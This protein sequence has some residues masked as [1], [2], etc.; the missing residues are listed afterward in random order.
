MQVI[1]VQLTHDELELLEKRWPKSKGNGSIEGRA[2]EIVQL[3]FGRKD[4]QC[5]FELPER[6]ADLHVVLSGQGEP[7]TIEV[8]GTVSRGLAWNQI[9]VSSANSWRLLTEKSM[10]VYRVSDVFGTSPTIFVLLHG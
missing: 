6:G 10:P 1:P 4:P 3:Y 2:V 8:K 9:K 5:A 7:L